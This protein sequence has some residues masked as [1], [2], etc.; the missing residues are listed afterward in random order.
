MNWNQT[1]MGIDREYLRRS[2]EMS[3]GARLDWLAAAWEFVQM[4][5]GKKPQRPE[6]GPQM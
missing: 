5:K 4:I 1:K 3:P 6:D 2:K